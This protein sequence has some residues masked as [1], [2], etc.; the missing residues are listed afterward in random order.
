MQSDA[1]YSDVVYRCTLD[2]M[3]RTGLSQCLE[4]NECLIVFAAM[5]RALTVAYAIT[6]TALLPMC[7]APS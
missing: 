2:V 4:P 7:G 6:V 5:Y 1:I 3:N